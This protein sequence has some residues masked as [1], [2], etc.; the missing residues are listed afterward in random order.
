M[1]SLYAAYNRL[2]VAR[3]VA[4]NVLSTAFL[5]GSG[6]FLAQHISSSGNYDLGRTIRALAYGGLIFAPIGIRWYKFLSSVKAPTFLRSLVLK[7]RIGEKFEDTIARVGVDQ[8]AFAPLVGVPLYFTALSIMEGKSFHETKENL[9]RT[10]W[11]TLKANWAVWPAFQF[12]NF[13]FIP[14]H[15]RLLGV[16]IT[17]LGWNCFILFQ[18]NRHHKTHAD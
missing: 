8:M 3:P 11:P 18:H 17:G 4:T 16:N 5:F 1:A 15:L 7:S 9:Q 10:W 2:L 6:D 12:L 14:P 13:A